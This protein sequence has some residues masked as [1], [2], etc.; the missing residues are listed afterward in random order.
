MSENIVSASATG[1]PSRRLFLAAGSAA[2]VF[3]GLHEA[4]ASEGGDA[5]LIALDRELEA[6]WAHEREMNESGTDGSV[7]AACAKCSEIVD[8]IG[9]IPATTLQGFKVKA[10]AVSWC[11]CGGFES[12]GGDTTDEMIAAQ[13]IRELLAI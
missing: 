3:S 5:A 2:A 10:R 8:R 9:K 12:F 1:L 7:E 13:I 11:H 4:A 6:A